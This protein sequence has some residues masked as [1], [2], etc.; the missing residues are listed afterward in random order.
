MISADTCSERELSSV[1][2]EL[3]KETCSEGAD[4]DDAV[5]GDTSSVQPISRIM[6]A[7]RRGKRT[8]TVQI[9]S[10]R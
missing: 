7:R 6:A 10:F 3:T 5:E 8:F 2:K 4:A 1:S 9:T